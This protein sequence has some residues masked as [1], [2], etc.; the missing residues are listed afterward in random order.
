MRHRLSGRTIL[1]NKRRLIFPPSRTQ[2]QIAYKL[3]KAR[4]RLCSLPLSWVNSSLLRAGERR[5]EDLR[6]DKKVAG[7]RSRRNSEKILEP[8]PYK[9]GDDCFS[10][11]FT[12]NVAYRMVA[13]SSKIR[14]WVGPNLQELLQIPFRLC[15]S[16]LSF[17][18]AMTLKSSSVVV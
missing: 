8:V 1:P 18:L 3:R 16:S 10:P 9:L 12:A 6:I 7:G 17:N 14:F 4:D 13:R 2:V 15:A 11:L 5:D